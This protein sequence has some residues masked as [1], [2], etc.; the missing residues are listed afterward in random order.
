MK[1]YSLFR[2]ACG[3]LVSFSGTSALAVEVNTDNRIFD[4]YYFGNGEQ[5]QFYSDVYYNYHSAYKD[6]DASDISTYNANHWN[7]DLKKA[8]EQ[9]VSTWTNAI[10]NSVTEDYGRKLR[11]GVFLDDGNVSCPPK[12]DTFGPF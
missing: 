6:Y 4:I 8:V 10:L 11:I 5:G 1:R 7:D 2:I 12:F 3:C 9:G